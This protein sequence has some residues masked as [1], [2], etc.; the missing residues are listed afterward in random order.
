MYY[1]LHFLGTV[2]AIQTDDEDRFEQCFMALGPSIVGFQ[3][4]IRPVVA[5]DACH[6]KGRYK[7]RL[8]I[9]TSMDGNVRI[10]PIAFGVGATENDEYWSWFFM[11]LRRAIGFVEDLVVISYRY[12]SIE[13]ACRSI[14]PHAVFGIC[15]YHL[16]MNMKAKF[17]VRA[18]DFLYRAAKAYTEMDYKEAMHVVQNTNKPVYDYLMEADPRKWSRCYF[19]SK[20]YS[21]MTTNIAE[22]MNAV[23][24]DAREYPLI[25]M[26]ETIQTMLQSWFHDRHRDAVNMP[27]PMTPKV[28]KKLTKRDDFSRR[29]KVNP[30]TDS[31]FHMIDGFRNARVDI[32][33]RTCSCRVFDLTELPCAHAIRGLRERGLSI[34]S[35]CSRYGIIRNV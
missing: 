28:E 34:Y 2:T 23:L 22:S 21:I 6:L 13:K 32:A 12:L 30:I 9:A 31:R 16:G 17:K 18:E 33:N 8:F 3:N 11:N 19:L 26:L 14:F 29:F 4:C 5:V 1:L 15:M 27:G 25:G 35:A 20:R 24:R 7:G 10:F